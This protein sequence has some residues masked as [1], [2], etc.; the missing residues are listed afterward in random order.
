[1]VSRKPSS[2]FTRSTNSSPQRSLASSRSSSSQRVPTCQCDMSSADDTHTKPLTVAIPHASGPYCQRRP[3]LQEILTNTSSPPWT[4]AAFM[5][6]LSANL[7]LENLEFTMDA[8][9]YKK[10]HAKMMA[11]AGE[12]GKP[13]VKECEYVRLLWVRLIDAYIAPNG[14]REVNLPSSV[15]DPILNASTTPM[16]PSPDTLT[17][18]VNKTHELME[19]SVLQPFLNSVQPQPSIS[20]SWQERS[21]F[22]ERPT[23]QEVMSAHSQTEHSMFGRK[24]TRDSPP[25]N[26]DS[27][28]GLNRVSGISKARMAVGKS[29]SSASGLSTTLSNTSDASLSKNWSGSGPGMTDDSGSTGSPTTD[30]PMT[31][32]MS[33]PVNDLS[34]QTSNTIKQ[35]RDSGM[36]KRFGRFGGMKSGKKRP[37]GE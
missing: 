30:T 33:P 8:G 35:N 1:M 23:T 28:T 18:A 20:S 25:P 6:Y 7:C 5:A 10:H 24:K 22:G 2:L 36:W 17:N 26:A 13:P 27:S 32:P 29:N 19:E 34:P 4:L 3:T 31:P 11:K 14:S 37:Q 15:R 16:P 9:R 12:D 21:H